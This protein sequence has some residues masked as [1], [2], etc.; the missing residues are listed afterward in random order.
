LGHGLSKCAEKEQSELVDGVD[1][2]DNLEEDS[3]PVLDEPQEKLSVKNTALLS[4]QFCCIWF[5]AN[6][7]NNMSYSLTLV[8]STTILASTSSIWTLLAGVLVKI[9]RLS[10]TRILAVVFSV[11]GVVLVA[12][13][14][15]RRSSEDNP[16]NDKSN[17]WVGNLMSLGSAFSYAIYITLLK[18]KIKDESR[19]SMMLFFGLVGV[20]N[21]LLF[22]PLFFLF[23]AIGLEHFSWPSGSRTWILLVLNGLLGT[24]LSEFLWLRASL[25][26]SPLVATVGLSLMTPVVLVFDTFLGLKL[27]VGYIIGSLFVVCGFL[28][29]NLSFSLKSQDEQIDQ[30]LF[31]KAQYCFNRMRGH[32]NYQ[33]LQD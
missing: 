33:S 29:V 19:V 10:S 13:S 21:F 2:S 27:T 17:S 5:I 20:F 1:A 32:A 24:A 9:E 30:W 18:I 8:T 26:T 16:Q 12:T 31:S 6:F 22:W 14:N 28:L 7:L 4:L 15:T 23:D 25:L 11:V 3:V